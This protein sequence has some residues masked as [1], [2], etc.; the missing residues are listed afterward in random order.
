VDTETWFRIA[1]RDVYGS[2]AISGA[3]MMHTLGNRDESALTYTN[4]FP[5]LPL[6]RARI[7]TLTVGGISNRAGSAVN[8]VR[9]AIEIFRP[10]ARTG[11]NLH[12]IYGAQWTVERVVNPETEVAGGRW[13]VRHQVAVLIDRALFVKIF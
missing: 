3:K 12:V 5:S 6:N 11:A 4:R 10:F 2:L 9:P 7:P 13:K 1:G 8:L